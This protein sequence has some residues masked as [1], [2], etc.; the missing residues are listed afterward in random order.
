MSNLNGYLYKDISYTSG[1]FHSNDIH[2]RINDAFTEDLSGAEVYDDYSLLDYLDSL[3]Y[4]YETNYR[5]VYYLTILNIPID[6]IYNPIAKIMKYEAMDDD[7]ESIFFIST[8]TEESGSGYVK[9]KVSDIDAQTISTILRSETLRNTSFIN[10][11]S[12]TI[13]LQAF[14]FYIYNNYTTWHNFKGSNDE[15]SYDVFRYVFSIILNYWVYRLN[16]IGK[17]MPAMASFLNDYIS[18]GDPLYVYKVNIEYD[19]TGKIG[20]VKSIFTGRVI[21]FEFYSSGSMRSMLNDDVSDVNSSNLFDMYG[22][23]SLLPSHAYS[24]MAIGYKIFPG[25]ANRFDKI[26]VEKIVGSGDIGDLSSDTYFIF[27]P[28]DSGLGIGDVITNITT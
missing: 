8:E 12:T 4:D 22:D 21:N 7:K 5:L 6:S 3:V 10:E 2:K 20:T 24:F 23:E 27:K 13:S 9:P 18:R 28:D 16:D 25:G 1:V 26:S 19:S 11:N 14:V 17:Y 15:I